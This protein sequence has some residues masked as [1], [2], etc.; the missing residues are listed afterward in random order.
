MD[1]LFLVL[2]LRLV[3]MKLPPFLCALVDGYND[4]DTPVLSVCQ[5][6]FFHLCGWERVG[7]A[8]GASGRTAGGQGRYGMGKYIPEEPL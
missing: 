2:K 5:S 7:V 6:K 1:E 8:T 3:N 4:Y